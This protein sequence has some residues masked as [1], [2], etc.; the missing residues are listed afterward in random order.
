MRA[1]AVL[2]IAG[3]LTVSGSAFSAPGTKPRADVVLLASPISVRP[4]HAGRTVDA[5]E[6]PAEEMGADWKVVVFRVE[7]VLKRNYKTLAV[8]DP[9]LWSQVKDAA[10]DRN[11]L[12]LVTMDFDKPSDELQEKNTL[13]IAVTDSEAV[14]GITEQALS[15]KRL[16]KI[17]LAQVQEQP[18]N[19]I[20]ISSEST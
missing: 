8:Q 5:L 1:A 12:K 13:S 11:I 20:M 10:D 15:E 7:R 6:K 4:A 9:S 19:Y 16:F 14:F 3:F 18:K 17:G 2:L